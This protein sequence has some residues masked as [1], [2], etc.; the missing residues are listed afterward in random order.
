MRSALAYDKQNALN[1]VC[2]YFTMFPLEYPLRVLRPFRSLNPVV[3]D[4]FCGRGTTLFA[5]RKLGLTSRGIDASPVAVAIARAKLCKIDA[6]QALKLAQRFFNEVHD[7]D[8]PESEFFSIAFSPKVLNQICAIRE[9]LLRIRRDSNASVLLRAAMLGCLH[10]PR[11]KHAENQSYFSNQMPRTFS[12]K[13]DYSIKYWKNN[14]LVPPDVDVLGVIQRKL[15]RIQ[16]ATLIEGSSIY[17]VRCGDS[18]YASSLPN[19]QRDH[20]IVVTSPP[21]YGMRTYIEDQWLRNW[22]VGGPDHIRYGESIQLHHTGQ[23]V[24]AESLG[25]V[26]TNVADTSEDDLRMFIRFGV[27]PSTNV[28]PRQLIMNS[29]ESSG[30]PWR[31]V[32]VRSAQSAS[33]GKRQAKQMTSKSEAATEYDF[34]I[35]RK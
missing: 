28:E 27:I 17:D 13:P 31:V 3:L 5:A 7:Y 35:L 19:R 4:P 9:G 26:W 1:A 21:Y 15:D 20:S 32:S 2:P 30:V 18:Q 29:L 33:S 22:F 25:K 11:S 34:H 6:N 14:N 24:F 8:I 12:S 10:G 23:D 16:K